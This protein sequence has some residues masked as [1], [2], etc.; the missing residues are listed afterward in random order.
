MTSFNDELHQ[1]ENQSP[2]I[3]GEINNI[4]N[5]N[6]VNNDVEPEKIPHHTYGQ[7][8]KCEDSLSSSSSSENLLHINEY[9]DMLKTITSL[10]TELQKSLFVANGL[11][12][13]NKRLREQYED[14]KSIL[15]R[16]RT[17]YQESRK[18]LLQQF[19]LTSKREKKLADA[20]KNW[21]KQI[22]EQNKIFEDK[23]DKIRRDELK[24]NINK[25]KEDLGKYNVKKIT[26]LKTELELWRKKYYEAK[27]DLEISSAKCEVIQ[28]SVAD[29]IESAHQ[30]RNEEVMILKERL[31]KYAVLD[32]DK[33]TI[34]TSSQHDDSESK[35]LRL[36]IERMKL[37]EDKLKQEI[38]EIRVAHDSHE[39]RYNEEKLNNQK[40]LV[41]IQTQKASLETEIKVMKRELSYLK[42]E[43]N[44]MIDQ[45]HQIDEELSDLKA[46]NQ[47]QKN[48]ISELD[49]SLLSSTTKYDVDS[50]KWLE[51]KTKKESML[52][53]TISRLT[54][55][56]NES[57]ERFSELKLEYMENSK[58]HMITSETEVRNL[59]E[60]LSEKM[61]ENNILKCHLSTMEQEQQRLLRKND[62]MIQK[63][64]H[65]CDCTRNELNLAT[66]E[67]E[68]IGK[69]LM[70]T[71]TV[72]QDLKNSLEKSKKQLESTVKEKKQLENNVE[73]YRQTHRDL[74]SSNK[75]LVTKL[76]R[77]AKDY[78]LERKE[79]NSNI[80]SI[81]SSRQKE[82][83]DLKQ[84][85]L[86]ER[87]RSEAY[88]QKALDSQRKAIE[89]KEIYSINQKN[90][91]T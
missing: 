22:E 12:E 16:T 91:I 10:Q 29:D 69:S 3:D 84:L 72:I 67:K 6:F 83:S 27:R 21:K 4:R 31:Q 62:F 30:A 87:R 52:Q 56:I 46:E 36:K 39:N 34:S 63:L 60:S 33:V 90:F 42:S 86:K 55:Q 20:E 58:G 47:H 18:S 45:K 61:T 65:D 64:I 23:E 17:R 68:A 15:D 2:T 49:A 79:F 88:K 19:E 28:K 35:S 1:S 53:E 7:H 54:A 81:N 40:E 57:E 38:R 8:R 14:T 13:E 43:N 85:F 80:K 11:E 66:K 76:Q 5:A 44:R 71:Q 70:S 89:M 48:T 9:Q 41:D 74:E 82:A 59:R 32:C 78:S 50:S 73:H 37:T 51:T 75:M 25:T 24:A 77:L 26:E